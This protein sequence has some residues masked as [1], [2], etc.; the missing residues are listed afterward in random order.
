VRSLGSSGA[1]SSQKETQ[2]K[3]VGKR[4]RTKNEKRTGGEVLS[5]SNKKKDL[6]R[7]QR[8]VTKEALGRT[9]KGKPGK[10]GGE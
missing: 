10:R 3:T 9:A 2:K 4:E 8:L 6:G 7:D 1:C 5:T